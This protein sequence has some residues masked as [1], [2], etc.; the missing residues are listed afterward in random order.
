MRKNLFILAVVAAMVMPAKSQLLYRISGNGLQKDSYIVGTFHLTDGTFMDEIPGCRKAVNSV[1][2]VCGELEFVSKTFVA[3]S[4][5]ILNQKMR[6]PDGK[7]LR[8]VMT[9]QQYEK[10]DTFVGK[11]LGMN[12]SN[13][14]LY[15][16]LGNLTPTALLQTIELTK[17]IIKMRK[18][19][20]EFN[21]QNAI[22]SYI[23][24]E[25]HDAGKK[26]L[27]L[28]TISFQ[29]NILFDTPIDEQIKSLMCAI[30][31]EQYNDERY[32]QMVKL[33]FEQKAEELY[34]ATIEKM[35]NECD[36]KPEDLDK[37][38][39]NRNANWI[40]LMPEIMKGGSTL[41]VVGAAHL[42]GKRGVLKG[43]Q[44]SGYTV[45]AVASQQVNH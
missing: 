8:D 43:L 17:C 10:V 16:Q 45:E 23:Q 18:Q 12:L 27:G 11:I 7:T 21:P 30:D 39:Y 34:E 2:Q 44:K 22:D 38:L 6:L 41:F 32:D 4:I 31:N 24:K 1:S 9:K 40:K 15:A 33:Y 28:E 14:T 3:D 25:A 35:G 36:A 19:G 13:P 20:K 5:A 42:G 26:T 37:I 29:A